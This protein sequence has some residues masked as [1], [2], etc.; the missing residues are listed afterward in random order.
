MRSHRRLWSETTTF[1]RL[2]LHKTDPETAE[3]TDCREK[4]VEAERVVRTG[5]Q[6][7]T[8]IPGSVSNQREVLRS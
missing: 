8:L 1:L 7:I 3:Q 5:T 4:K 2:P 6:K